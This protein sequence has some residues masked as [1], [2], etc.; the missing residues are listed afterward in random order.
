MR[1]FATGNE[2]FF[3]TASYEN[4]LFIL[5]S[6]NKTGVDRYVCFNLMLNENLVSNK[7]DAINNCK[8]FW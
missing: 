1:W 2:N 5:A 4:W 3:K 8:R 6:Q 7:F